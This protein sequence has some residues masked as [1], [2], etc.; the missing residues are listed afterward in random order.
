MSDIIIYHHHRMFQHFLTHWFSFNYYP[1][2]SLPTPVS[3]STKTVLNKC[4]DQ[5]FPKTNLCIKYSVFIHKSRSTR[6]GYALL[7]HLWAHLICANR[8]QVVEVNGPVWLESIT[9][10]MR[11]EKNI[12]ENICQKKKSGLKQHLDQSKLALPFKAASNN[13]LLLLLNLFPVWLLL[14]TACKYLW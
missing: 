8:Q 3:S 6:Q 7:I 10:A 14:W 1:Q 9:C 4:H 13:L 12:L 11:N 5:I 2:R